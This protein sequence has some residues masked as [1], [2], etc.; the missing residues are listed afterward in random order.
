MKKLAIYVTVIVIENNFFSRFMK[1][2]YGWHLK[3]LSERRSLFKLQEMA[4]VSDFQGALVMEDFLIKLKDS[5]LL[6]V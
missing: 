3:E 1:V 5:W 6:K 2:V 4:V